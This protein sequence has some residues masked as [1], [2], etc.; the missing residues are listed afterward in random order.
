MKKYI[1]S[2]SFFLLVLLFTS[3]WL[4]IEAQTCKPSGK[5]R[6]KTPPPGQ[7]NRDHDSDCCK[8][9]DV[10]T[11]YKCS[12]RVS[13]RTKATLTLN[14]FEKGADGGAPS[15]CDNQ[16]HSDNTPVVALSTGWFNNMKR[17]LH[18]IT[19]FGNGRSVNA[20]VV[21]ECDSTMGCDSDHDYQPPCR[22]N[23]VDASKAVW[24][25][26]KV[27]EDNWGELDIYWTDA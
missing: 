2:A 4:S 23:I 19:I 22:N 24:K 20:M 6:G 15:E 21:D 17:C 26:L 3:N 5:I 18:N 25:A 10:Y 12:P 7:C 1:S 13:G 9:G 8:Q 27:P 11:T 16:Y 14:G